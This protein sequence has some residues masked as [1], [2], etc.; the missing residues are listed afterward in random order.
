MQPGAVS[1]EGNKVSE[2]SIGIVPHD[3]DVNKKNP[4]CW[5]G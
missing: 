4:K 5:Q 3:E 2:R 1:P